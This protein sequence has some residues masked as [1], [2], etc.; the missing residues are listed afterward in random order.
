[1]EPVDDALIAAA[2]TAVGEQFLTGILDFDRSLDVVW[3]SAATPVVLGWDQASLVGVNALELIDP[4]DIERVMPIIE[5]VLGAPVPRVLPPAAAH[6]LELSLKV[7]A[8]DESSRPVLVAGRVLGDTGHLVVTVR[9]GGERLAFD[10]VLQLLGQGEQ[11]GDTLEAL[12]DVVCIHFDTNAALVHAYDE[13]VAVEGDVDAL[14]GAD[15]GTVLDGALVD[16]GQKIWTDGERWVC[17]VV[18]HGGAAV[19]GAVVFPAPLSG[20]PT[21]YDVAIVERVTALA[22]L[23]FERAVHD[24]RLHRDASIDGLTGVLN[25]RSFERRLF[26]LVVGPESPIVVAF[27]D[28]DGLKAIND[29]EGHAAGDRVLVHVAESLVAAV[30]S[31]D[32]VGRIGGD[33]FVVAFPGL[34]VERASDAVAR[35]RAAVETTLE[36]GGRSVDVGLSIGTA[37]AVDRSGLASVLE[38]SDLAMYADKRA[39]NDA[40]GR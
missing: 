27:A 23:A 20:D 16:G 40:A 34:D 15:A 30:R 3:A 28:L 39:R 33:E 5:P 8:Q 10:R 35:L 1:M 24:R 12:L 21:P 26:A 22:A 36:L 37:S 7:I 32:F 14:L 17:P 18:S 11:L 2:L 6:A 19:F 25:R 29:A 9:P 4:S 38:R 31:V 13:S